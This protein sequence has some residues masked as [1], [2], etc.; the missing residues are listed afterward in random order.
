ML[1]AVTLGDEREVTLVALDDAAGHAVAGAGV[2]A[3]GIRLF[4]DDD[5]RTVGV[6][7]G[8][9]SAI[10]QGY[11]V[12]EIIRTGRCRRFQRKY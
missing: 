5:G 4:V 1:S 9:V 12:G 10:V 8:M 11:G 2:G 7:Q 3:I 6:K